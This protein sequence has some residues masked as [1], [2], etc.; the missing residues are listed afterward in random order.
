MRIAKVFNNSVVLGVDER[1]R[2]VVLLGRGIGFQAAPG[3]PVRTEAIEKRFVPGGPTSVERLAGYLEDI[4]AEDIDLTEEILLLARE[5]FGSQ[6]SEHALLP[7]AD[8]ISFALRRER[9]GMH[10]EYPLQ[11]EVKH[12]YPN[13][14]AFAERALALIEERRG[15]RLPPLE[16]VPLALH[17]VN[18]QFGAG[19]M[20]SAFQATKAL[21][22]AV[23]TVGEEFGTPIEEDSVDFSR[24]I[25]HVRYLIL[26]RMR[27]THPPRMDE[28]ISSALRT[29]RP[30]AW[31]AAERIADILEEQFGW[32]VGADE[33]LYLALHVARLTA[34][35]Q[36]DHPV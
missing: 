25:T 7:L 17:F 5:Q 31:R 24:F 13:E 28:T 12:L 23:Q 27:D 33:R 32:T 18:A 15:V 36:E 34:R 9:E 14:V 29:A 1:G 30:V 26:R 10:F 11:W 16:A 21:T 8:H 35:Q 2:E 19:D 4:P 20:S 3:Q 22:A 6:F